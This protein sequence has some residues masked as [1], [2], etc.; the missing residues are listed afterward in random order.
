[1]R[2]TSWSIRLLHS[3]AGGGVGLKTVV[4]VS[5]AAFLVVASLF[6]ARWFCLR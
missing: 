4:R 1:L 3:L 6:V 2:R 5:Q